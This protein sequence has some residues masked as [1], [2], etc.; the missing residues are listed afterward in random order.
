MGETENKKMLILFGVI[1]TTLLVI[2]TSILALGIPAVPVCVIVLLEAG[3][4]VCLHD[5]PIWLHGLVVLAQV[6]AGLATGKLVFMLL[7]CVIYLVGIL[8]LKLVR[9]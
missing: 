6:I 7:C 1:V 9:D 8:A 4:A 3:I 5:V 2:L